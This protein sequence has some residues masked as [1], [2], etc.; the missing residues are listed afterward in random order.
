M[1][2]LSLDQL[3]SDLAVNL[4]SHRAAQGIAQERLALEAG[5]DRTVVSKIERGVT[6]PSLAILLK[7]ANTLNID[8][9]DLLKPN[10]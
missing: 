4:R 10:N 8:V 3:K 1:K 2:S 9:S 6:N 7:L 5:V